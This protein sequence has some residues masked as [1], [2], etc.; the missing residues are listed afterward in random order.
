M[1]ATHRRIIID[2][3]YE[4]KEDDETILNNLSLLYTHPVININKL[5][6][7]IREKN[8]EKDT[9]D[10]IE[11]IPLTT[12]FNMEQQLGEGAM[13]NYKLVLAKFLR[14]N[15]Y[16]VL[17]EITEDDVKSR[18]D[19]TNEKNKSLDDVKLTTIDRELI[20]HINWI[21]NVIDNIR[22]DKYF[23]TTYYNMND[24][25]YQAYLKDGTIPNNFV[26]PRN[27]KRNIILYMLVS[28]VLYLD[29]TAGRRISEFHQIIDREG[30]YII[31]KP[32]KTEKELDKFKP[33]IDT[34][35]WF[36]YYQVLSPFLTDRFTLNAYMRRVNR[37]LKRPFLYY[38]TGKDD[39]IENPF[40]RYNI[41]TTHQLRKIYA[42]LCVGND[43]TNT[44]TTQILRKMQE[45]LNQVAVSSTLH[46]TK[47]TIDDSVWK[48]D[49]CIVCGK[50]I[51]RKKKH[52]KTKTHIKN[53]EKM[54]FNII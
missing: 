15:N 6:R 7:Q 49:R 52:E 26:D 21:Q 34:K 36:D 35:K 8:E 43:I 37:Q 14:K 3:I 38:N 46:Y 17:I 54:N 1:I 29:I 16:P 47:T 25:E 4:N 42:K 28:L 41:A 30:D 45:C 33:L 44:N 9:N 39:K 20:K 32:N 12:H 18:R 19:Y 23:I 13:T 2:K 53:L 40:R 10:T 11:T 22:H 5:K 27:E 51:A 50:D 48:G 24:D 31:Y